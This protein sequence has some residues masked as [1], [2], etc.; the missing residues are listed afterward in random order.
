MLLLMSEAPKSV[1]SR[2]LCDIEAFG[3]PHAI[4]GI[5]FRPA[6]AALGVS[7]WGMNVL[8]FDAGCTGHP[9]HDHRKDRQEEVYF[10]VSGSI[11]LA[12]DDERL[13]LAEHDFVRI[14]AEVTRKILPGPSGATVLAIGAVP[15][16]PYES[17][18]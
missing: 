12:M 2:S 15:G 16:K 9:E 11:T 10:V 18:F 8:E 7:S 13:E 6:A 17:M 3:G 4:E 5:R 1:V 14:P